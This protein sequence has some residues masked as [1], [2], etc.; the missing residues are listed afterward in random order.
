MNP[1]LSR[2]ELMGFGVFAT[3]SMLAANSHA[4]DNAAKLSPTTGK[5]DAS[6]YDFKVNTSLEVVQRELTL[7]EKLKPGV[8]ENGMLIIVEQKSL[9]YGWGV[10]GALRQ[11]QVGI[12]TF[13]GVSG[14]RPVGGCFNEWD[15]SRNL[16]HFGD[17]RMNLLE[18]ARRQNQVRVAGMQMHSTLNCAMGYVIG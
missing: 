7:P 2:R 15:G 16:P 9:L 17:A 8:Y 12:M 10:I 11:G 3:A 5:L 4:Q 13:N 18:V 1:S 14:S 6:S